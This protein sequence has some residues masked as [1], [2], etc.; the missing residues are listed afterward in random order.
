VAVPALLAGALVWAGHGKSGPVSRRIALSRNGCTGE[1]TAPKAGRVTFSISNRATRA[2][3]IELISTTTSAI[4]AE[5]EVLGPGTTRD[6]PVTL[7]ADRYAWRCV[8]D[9]SA[10]QVSAAVTVS[11]RGD[12]G[13]SRIP[14]TAAEMNAPL[15]SYAVF[16]SR[17]LALLKTQVAAL[18]RDTSAGDLAKA[19]ESWLT[20]HLTWHRIGAAYNAFGD[21]G[22]AVDGLAQGLSHGVGD[23]GFA[24]FHKIEYDLW[25]GGSAGTIDTEVGDLATAVDKLDTQKFT[26]DPKDV[27]TRAHEI[28][29]DTARFQ[30][31]GQ[32]DYGSG[33]SIA[34]A[35]A[36]VDGERTLL[37]MLAPLIGKRAPRL[38]ATAN[39][40]LDAIEKA[41]GGTKSGGQWVAVKDLP[42]A[43][44]Q[45]LNAAVGQ[46]VETLAP[47]PN[48]LEIQKS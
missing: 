30:L 33:S 27:A 8:F 31:T 11:G 39:A 44:R 1:W 32:D 23:K 4:A 29:E 35:Q 19:R 9:G 6:L 18:R 17:Q 34:S 10:A 13:P 45:P 21:E 2:V 22:K 12:A 38:V 36:D 41:I 46:A 3:D 37:G 43:R 5:I 14:L 26:L 16:V 24:G 48:L 42:L 28:L 25:H 7:S 40:D 20:A 47:V 15:N